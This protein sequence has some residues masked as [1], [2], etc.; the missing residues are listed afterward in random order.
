MITK[1][2]GTGGLRLDRHR[3]RAA[4]LRDRGRRA[5]S[6]PDVIARFDTLKLDAGGPRPRARLGRAR[7]AAAAD[8]QGVHQLLRRLRNSMTVLLAGLDVERKAQ[9]RARRRC[10]TR[11]AARRSSPTSTSGSS[12]GT[13]GSR[14][15]RGGVRDLAYDS[16]VARRRAG[17]PQVLLD[18]GGAWR[19][20]ACRGSS[21]RTPPGD[22][23]RISCTGRRWSTPSGCRS[24]VD[25]GRRAHHRCRRRRTAGAGRRAAA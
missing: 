6:N 18:G 9:H 7:R 22:A 10:S 20:R 19:S 12:A 25:A 13:A 14:A 15:Q 23:S 2:P 4:A 8:H 17:G 24:V 5:T 1:H 11:S 16:H 21:S 3:H